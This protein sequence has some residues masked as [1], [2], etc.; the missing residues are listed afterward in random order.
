MELSTS[1]ISGQRTKLTSWRSHQDA[2]IG[3]Y[4]VSLERLSIPEVLIWRENQHQH[5]WRSGPWNG[6]IFLGIPHMETN[7]LFGF[8]LGEDNANTNYY[9]AY[10]YANSSL[11][12]Y[13]MLSA[14]GNLYEV[15][16]VHEKKDWFITWMAINSECD[17]YGRCGEF[18]ICEHRSSPICSC[19]RGYEQG[20]LRSG[21]NRTG[22]VVVL[23][24][25]LCSVRKLEIIKKMDLGHKLGFTDEDQKNDTVIIAAPVIIGIPVRLSSGKGFK[26]EAWK[27]WKAGNTA[28]LIDP[29]IASS[30]NK[31]DV[32]RCIHIGLLCVQELARDRP[33]MTSVISMLNSETIN[34][35]APKKPAFIL[36]QT[37]LD[38]ES[39]LTND[40]LG[41]IN[42]V[43]VTDIQGR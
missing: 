37:M 10:N 7:Y 5:R 38:M 39:S 33:T 29:E 4:S 24:R 21:I 28:S 22:A 2:S 43:T 13:Y 42:N 16:W 1:N 35:P 11:D 34:L 20:I 6:Q 12:T 41:S 36:R 31:E 26:S 18:G 19:L 27:L 40:G 8:Y 25:N 14:D 23:G 3:E 9:L 15:Y 17:V 30:C 32:I